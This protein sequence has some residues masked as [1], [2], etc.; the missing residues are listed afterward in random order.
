MVAL[1]AVPAVLAVTGLAA[2]PAGAH[3][4]GGGAVFVSAHGIDSATCGRIFDPCRTIGQGVTNV[5]SGG[6]VT[7]LRGSY[8]ESVTIDKKVTLLGVGATVD[9]SGSDHGIWV[10]GPS[11]SGS[12]VSG[13][14]VKNAIGEGILLTAVDH[15]TVSRNR[16]TNNDKGAHTSVYP[17][18]ADNGPVPG[19]CGEAIHLQGTTNSKIV[20]NRVDHNIGGVLVTDEAGPTSGNLIAGNMVVDNAEDCGITMPAHVAGLGVTNNTVEG[21]YIARNGGAGVLIATPGPGMAVTGN[22]VTRNIIVNNGEGGV[23]L[24]AHAPNQSIDDNTITN[25]LIGTNNTAG[26]KDSGDLKTSGIIV[27]SAVVPVQGLVVDH[28]V[29]F[30]DRIGIWLSVSVDASGITHNKFVNVATPVHQ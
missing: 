22:L 15:V 6:R 2:S 1:F 11:A 17:P 10:M 21:N 12:T 7:A 27:F 30:N 8:A 28:N 29:I 14:T 18:C 19:D 24:H 3:A 4:G 16:V 20:S 5:S 13:F 26:D 23:Q 9:A 25:N